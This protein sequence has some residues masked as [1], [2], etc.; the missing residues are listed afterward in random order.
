MKK[1][2]VSVLALYS[3]SGYACEDLL[4]KGDSTSYQVNVGRVLSNPNE[5]L[6]EQMAENAARLITKETG[7]QRVLTITTKT[8]KQAFDRLPPVCHVEA[9]NLGGY[10]LITKDYVDN[11]N[12]IFNRYD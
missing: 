8:C 1:L 5:H 12:I 10:F 6:D 9:S 2:L 4:L 3:L 11:V 7:C